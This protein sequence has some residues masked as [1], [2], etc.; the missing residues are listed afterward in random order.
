MEGRLPL[1]FLAIKLGT[2]RLRKLHDESSI[3][4]RN[5]MLTCRNPKP[6]PL[7]TWQFRD[8]V[9]SGPLAFSC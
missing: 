3:I 2:K 8:V 6:F 4:S 1:R 9:C 7:T 5:L